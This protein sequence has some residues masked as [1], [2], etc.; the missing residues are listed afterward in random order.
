MDRQVIVDRGSDSS[1]PAVMAVVLVALAL[2]LGY[3][4]FEGDKDVINI[5]TPQ[6]QTDPGAALNPGAADGQ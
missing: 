1:A 4:Y 6:V 2:V 3:F 5:Q